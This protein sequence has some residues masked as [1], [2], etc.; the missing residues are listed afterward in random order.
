[1]NKRHFLTGGVAAVAGLA[2]AGWAWWRF[3]PHA[4]QDG[5]LQALWQHTWDSPEGQP[6]AMQQFKGRP[7][8][9][10]FWATWCPPCVEEMPMLNTFYRERR[11]DGW[12]VLGLAVDQPS[13]VRQF[14]QRWPVDFPIGMAGLGGTELSRQLGNPNGGLPF[15]VVFDAQGEIAHR[16]IGQVKP[17]DLVAW[18]QPL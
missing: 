10:N 12:T 1:M 5:A 9:L 7:L 17:E 2:G 4:V 3:Q 14:L 16:K 18:A 11:A 8:L 15:T 13:A 6:V